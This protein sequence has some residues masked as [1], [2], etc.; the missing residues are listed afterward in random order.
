MKRFMMS[1]ASAAVVLLMAACG[2]KTNKTA[3]DA[4][5]VGTDS[6][7]TDSV[8]A[9]APEVKVDKHTEDYL[10]ER[11]DSFYFRYKNPKYQKDGMRIYN[12]KGTIDKDSAFLSKRFKA[13]LA[14]A[15]AI[16]KENEEP[17]LDYDHWTNSQDDNNF[18]YEVGKIS[19][20]TDS[21]AI[22]TINAKNFGNR[23]NV[24]LR[25]LFERD[26]WFVDD[27]LLSDGSGETD[28]YEYYIKYNTFYQRFALNDLLYLTEYYSQ[29]S[30][31]EKSG[32]RLI[33][34]DSDRSDEVDCDEYVYGR[35]VSRSTKKAFG[36]ELINDTPHAF[37]F[38]MS[39]DTGTNGRLYFANQKDANSFYERT[40]N[41]KPF[42]FEGKRI[43][44]SKQADG[45]SFLV[46]ELLNDKSTSTMFAIHRP[47]LSEQYYLIEVE[48]YV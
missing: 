22:V 21:T 43:V 33:Y 34:H 32:L 38:S 28:H 20:M 23:Y 24:R 41:S 13:L 29:T 4:D 1:F 3:S 37:Y 8:V 18:T 35:G 30:K 6:A 44:V 47:V 9:S 17:L 14:K 25:M 10:R 36:Y 27:F 12:G 11:V 2:G 26:D 15:E 48:I 45:K 19:Q 42:T 7:A 31:A 5:S 39:L 46:Q 16:A 40:R